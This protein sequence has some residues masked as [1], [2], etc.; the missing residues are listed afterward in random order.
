MPQTSHPVLP[1]RAPAWGGEAALLIAGKA[2]GQPR[3]RNNSAGSMEIKLALLLHKDNAFR[4]LWIIY[5]FNFPSN[6]AIILYYW[7]FNEY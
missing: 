5:S 1:M 7:I 6:T 3:T 2:P 4:G